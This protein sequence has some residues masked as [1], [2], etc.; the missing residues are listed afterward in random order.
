MR[1]INVTKA[2]ADLYNL[3][4]ET[5]ESHEPIQIT[6]KKSNAILVSEEDWRSIQETLHLLSIPGM[7][8]SIIEGLNADV[9]TDA[10]E[11]DW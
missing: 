5:S 6:G 10:R 1:T 11:L 4:I 8:E 2:R 9:E 3:L 7:R